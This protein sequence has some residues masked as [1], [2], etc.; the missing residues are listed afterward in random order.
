M[1]TMNL[2]MMMMLSSS[3][4]DN[5]H[6]DDNRQDNNNVMNLIKNHHIWFVHIHDAYHEL[7]EVQRQYVMM[8]M[9]IQ[10]VVYSMFDHYYNFHLVMEYMSKQ[11]R[12]N[13]KIVSAKMND[14]RVFVVSFRLSRH[15]QYWFKNWSAVQIVWTSVCLSDYSCLID[16]R[17]FT[18]L[19]C[20]KKAL[21]MLFLSS[22]YSSCHQKTYCPSLVMMIIMLIMSVES[23][24]CRVDHHRVC[25]FPSISSSSSLSSSKALFSRKS[26]RT[27][28]R[29]LKYI[30]TLLFSH[31]FSITRTLSDVY[32]SSVYS[33]HTFIHAC[34]TNWINILPS[35]IRFE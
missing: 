32:I 1:K 15:W 5:S 10:W 16:S 7:E 21:H 35:T 31:Y 3:L 4:D 27:S 20:D 30:T 23:V 33:A 25:G 12:S 14:D 19:S 29:I 17:R 11:K 24:R 26:I 13:E 22:C 9:D 28:C 6:I 2:S 8:M 34:R 18:P